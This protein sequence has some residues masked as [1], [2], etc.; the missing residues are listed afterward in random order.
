V[1]DNQQVDS[2]EPEEVDNLV[3]EEVDNHRAVRM[4]VEVDIQRMEELPGQC[5]TSVAWGALPLLIEA[6]TCHLACPF[7]P[8]VVSANNPS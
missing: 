3:P 4:L 2:H 6:Q 1:E 7:G 5:E 8:C